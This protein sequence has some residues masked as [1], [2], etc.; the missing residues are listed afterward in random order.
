MVSFVTLQPGEYNTEEV[1][2]PGFDPTVP[3]DCSGTIAEG[4]HLTCT[5]TN[6]ISQD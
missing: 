6:T 5:I 2:G 1:I 4:Q 3:S